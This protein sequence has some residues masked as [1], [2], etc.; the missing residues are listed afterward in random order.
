MHVGDVLDRPDTHDAHRALEQLAQTGVVVGAVDTLVVDP[1][2]PRTR[3]A[4]RRW[5]RPLGEVVDTSPSHAPDARDLAE[6]QQPLDRDL[7]IAPVPPLRGA[8]GATH[9]CRRERTLDGQLPAYLGDGLGRFL[10]PLESTTSKGAPAE[11]E[12]RPLLHRQDRRGVRPVLEAGRLS[13]MTVAATTTPVGRLHA[14]AT[15]RAEP[16][17]LDE[18]VA[19]RQDTHRVEL[20]S[21]EVPQCRVDRRATPGERCPRSLRGPQRQHPGDQA[22][23]IQ[24]EQPGLTEGQLR[25]H[26][27]RTYWRAPTTR[28]RRGGGQPHR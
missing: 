15:D 2:L 18:L 28:A 12:Q 26:E 14:V 11:R 8:L 23:R 9:L 27:H 17:V 19:A 10:V 3:R 22:L 13:R 1:R 4:V 7:R 5:D 16:R 20:H 25:S 21:A 6:Q 24:R